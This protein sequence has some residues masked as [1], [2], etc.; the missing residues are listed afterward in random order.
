[1]DPIALLIGWGVPAKLAKPL[2]IGVGILLLIGAIFAAVKI[3]D[4]RVIKQH[5][6]QQQAANAIADR[7]ADQQAANSRVADQQRA[8]AESAQIK[9]A[10]NEAGT[11]P[12]A[13]RAAYYKC[14]RAQ[15]DARRAGKL[16]PHC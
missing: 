5:E 4:H 6:A 7:K 11:D 9:E 2:L 14:V 3:H 12:A 13:R 15:Q 16:A 1:M 8:D 10:V